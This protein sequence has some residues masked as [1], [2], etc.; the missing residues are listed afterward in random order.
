MYTHLR[1]EG[2]TEEQKKPPFWQLQKDTEPINRWHSAEHLQYN[3]AEQKPHVQKSM[4]KVGPNENT[5][6]DT[7]P[8]NSE[9]LRIPV[10]SNRFVKKVASPAFTGSELV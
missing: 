10:G 4:E 2:H 1:E 3:L 7:M 5:G 6:L 8:S 9:R